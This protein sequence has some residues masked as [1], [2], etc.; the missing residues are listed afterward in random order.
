MEQT[1]LVTETAEAEE[2]AQAEDAASGDR[3]NMLLG[4]PM[5][6]TWMTECFADLTVPSG[7]LVIFAE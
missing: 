4:C 2:R 5:L 3:R 6:V 1:M 7:R